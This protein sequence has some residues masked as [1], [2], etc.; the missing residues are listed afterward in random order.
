MQNSTKS[1][2]SVHQEATTTMP[3]MSHF[4]ILTSHIKSTI[5]AIFSYFDFSARLSF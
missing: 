5:N 3:K 1:A 2:I 4:K